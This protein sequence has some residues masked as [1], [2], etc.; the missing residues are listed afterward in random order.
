V[1]VSFRLRCSREGAHYLATGQLVSLSEQLCVDCVLNGT[2][3]C[4]IGGEMHDCY[5]QVTLAFRSESSDTGTKITRSI[6]S[7]FNPRMLS[8]TSSQVI[9][10]G[11]DEAEEAYPYQGT[12][13][14]PCLFTPQRVVAKFSS[15]KN[16]T[17]GDEAALKVASAQT[18]ISVGIDASSIW[19]QLYSSGVY[20]D[21][22][23]KVISCKY[24]PQIHIFD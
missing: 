22:S 16:V 7:Q 10:E 18:V 12:S 2:D 9:A 13:G 21:S 8:S 23:C 24:V 11:G 3:T 19:F 6:L 5:L 20:D 1:F 14:G 17:Q 4:S 15:Y